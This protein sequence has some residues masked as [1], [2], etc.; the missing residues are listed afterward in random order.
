LAKKT[1]KQ[2]HTQ[3]RKQLHKKRKSK[4]QAMPALLRR[5]PL[6]RGALDHSHPLVECLI[7]QD[8]EE[9]REAVVFVIRE[10][11]T[12]CV[13][14]CFVVD[15]ADA[16]LGDVWGNCALS[17]S[18]IEE[19]K[20]H[21]TDTGAR[22]VACNMSLAHDIVLGGIAWARKWRFKLPKDY[23]IWLRILA[24]TT[25]D[26]I[27][28]DLFGEN[29]KPISMVMEDEAGAPGRKRFDP[30]ILS[31]NLEPDGN[32][33]SPEI[34]ESVGDIKQGLVDF[35]A[36]AEFRPEFEAALAERYDDEKNPESEEELVY[37]VDRF[38]LE[39]Q[40]ENGETV[41]RRFVDRYSEQM[42]KSVR[43]LILDWEEVIEGLFEIK[44]RSGDRFDMKNL[45][46]EREYTVF[47]TVPSGFFDI[48]ADDF[49]FARIAPALGYHIFSGLSQ[50]FKSDGSQRQRAEIYRSAIELQMKN[51]HWAFR[52]NP[53]KLQKSRESV[54]QQ[55]E[56]FLTCFGTD[57]VLGTGSE[58]LEKSQK[59][60]DFLTARAID[61]AGDVS[62][63]TLEAYAPP[64]PLRA[65]LPKNLLRSPDVGML[66]D[67]LEGISF[68]NHYRQFVDIFRH[69]EE[70]LAQEETGDFL[71]G[72]LEDEMVSDV[73]FSRVAAKFP[74]NFKKVF[75]YYGD[76]IGYYGESVNDLMRVFK[77][78][79]FDKLPHTVVLMDAEMKRVADAADVKTGGFLNRMKGVF[80][81]S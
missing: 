19:L 73:P 29:G 34:L 37:F 59:L 47:S 24:P 32:G 57:E 4:Q 18:D 28:P 80:W 17:R 12:G 2:K 30:L 71:L 26:K 3:K 36:G 76:D 11:P 20:S 43:R 1:K 14:A 49:L 78:D 75:E 72:Y 10:A 81:K 56:D 44:D 60:L 53:E 7:N 27:D 15:L 46:N 58:I 38:I 5:E 67:P 66:C 41:A 48:D 68:L 77:P 69:P 54:R 74:D 79:S 25:E 50:T 8:W 40:L 52:D 51:P 62:P 21:P 16:G 23:K 33:L 70:H 64:E 63:Q 65:Q 22:L 55:C 45:V 39:H 35:S 61:R 42:S 9:V 31:A 6:L 13:F